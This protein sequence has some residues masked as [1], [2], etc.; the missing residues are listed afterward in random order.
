LWAA[1]EETLGQVGCAIA[2]VSTASPPVAKAS[3]HTV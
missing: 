2:V 1:C 3:A